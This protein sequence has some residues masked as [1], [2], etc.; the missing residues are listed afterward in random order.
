MAQI[1]VTTKITVDGTFSNKDT[2]STSYTDTFTEKFDKEFTLTTTSAVTIWDPIS[3]NPQVTD[4]TTCLVQTNATAG[5]DIEF[6]CGVTAASVNFWTQQVRSDLPIMFNAS[7]SFRNVTT[8]DGALT[9][10]TDFVQINK[11]RACNPTAS[12]TV[13]VRLIL[14]S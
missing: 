7:G 4:F 14:V 12:T 11:I 2:V 5:V 10:A 3:D 8:T 13:T 6:A 9:A 1:S